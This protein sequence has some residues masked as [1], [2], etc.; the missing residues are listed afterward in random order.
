MV[1]CPGQRAARVRGAAPGR[2]AAWEVCGRR[3]VGCPGQRAARVRGAAPGRGA[4]WEV[5]GRWVP[6]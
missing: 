5:C 4:A 1:G 3:S 2:G 6:C